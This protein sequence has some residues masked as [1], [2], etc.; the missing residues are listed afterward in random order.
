MNESIEHADRRPRRRPSGA[1]AAPVVDRSRSYRH[2][3]NPFEPLKVFSDDQIAAI[4][5]AALTIL[6]NQGMRVLLEE[7]RRT[8]A[9]G[10]A[11][12]DESTLM[13]RIDR[14]LVAASL[15]TAPREI[16]LHAK[17][18]ERNMPIYGR[19]VAFAP[20]SG[21]PNVMD[22]AGGRRAGTFNDFCNM[23]KLCQ[24]FEV[25]HVLGG[26]T[27]PRLRD[28]R[29]IRELFGDFPLP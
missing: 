13:V 7:G 2:L 17:D 28:L 27:E 26:A 11:L 5:E 9:R 16:T 24:S 10:G 29:R 23:V 20:T 18:P 19:H 4:H 3:S 6:E 15:A 8:Y 14:G 22:T 1:A 12:V 25:M 21:P